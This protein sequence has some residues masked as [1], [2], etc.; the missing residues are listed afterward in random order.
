MKARKAS[1]AAPQTVEKSTAGSASLVQC[2]LASAVSLCPLC[3][4][5]L[6]TQ[7]PNPP[8]G[9]LGCV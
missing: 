1:E 2:L 6:K 3:R 5:R 8:S 4:A 9:G 7:H